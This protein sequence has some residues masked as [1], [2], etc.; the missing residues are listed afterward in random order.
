MGRLGVR[1]DGSLACDVDLELQLRGLTGDDKY[2]V[3]LLLFYFIGIH[4]NLRILMNHCG[5]SVKL[6]EKDTFESKCE[7]IKKLFNI[8]CV[9]MSEIAH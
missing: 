1:S 9:S 4:P 2:L 3:S 6:V 7:A 5:L 8:R